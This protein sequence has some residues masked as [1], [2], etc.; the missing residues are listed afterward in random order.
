MKRETSAEGNGRERRVLCSPSSCHEESYPSHLLLVQCWGSLLVVHRGPFSPRQHTYSSSPSA[1]SP[2]QDHFL[3]Y[4]SKWERFSGKFRCESL[5]FFHFYLGRGPLSE[6]G[7]G[8]Q[9]AG[10]GKMLVFAIL[11]LT[12]KPFFRVLFTFLEL[13]DTFCF[14]IYFLGFWATSSDARGFSLCVQESLLSLLACSKDH[15]WY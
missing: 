4:L 5:N 15:M 13:W 11:N 6:D 9:K 10:L 8:G 12:L 14:F 7:H 2:A 3:V 1:L